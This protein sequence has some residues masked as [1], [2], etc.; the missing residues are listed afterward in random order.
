[1]SGLTTV[2]GT[3]F[4]DCIFNFIPFSNVHPNDTHFEALMISCIAKAFGD[5]GLGS[6]SSFARSRRELADLKLPS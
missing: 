5:H 6:Y 2:T 4:T 1:M 3:Y